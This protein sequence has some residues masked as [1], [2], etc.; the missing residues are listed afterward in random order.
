[1]KAAMRNI[2]LIFVAATLPV[3]IAVAD[4]LIPQKPTR[5]AIGGKP[6]AVKPNR[7][8]N[9]CAAY[10]PGFVKVEGS[11]TCVRLGGSVGVGVGGR[12]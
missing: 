2:L 5:T 7:A 4:P 6:L 3:S 11:D 12:R 10:G 1:M 8:S 9:A